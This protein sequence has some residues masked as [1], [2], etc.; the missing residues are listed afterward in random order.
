M[1]EWLEVFMLHFSGP[2]FAGS[3]PGCRPTHRSS[4]HAVEASHIQSGGGLAHMLAQGQSSSGKK[5]GGLAMNVSL[6]RIFLTKINK[7]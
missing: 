1:A 3:D 5:G 2:G 6:G 7:K 4:N